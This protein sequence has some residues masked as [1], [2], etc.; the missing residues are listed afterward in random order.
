MVASA[1]M[2]ALR[3]ATFTRA[4]KKNTAPLIKAALTHARKNL[5]APT[6]ALRKVTLT[7]VNREKTGVARPPLG[8]VTLVQQLTFWV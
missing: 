5:G 6:P 2:P 7:H 1:A 4:Y 3:E 8:K